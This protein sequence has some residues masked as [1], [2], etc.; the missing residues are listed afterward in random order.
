MSNEIF[1]LWYKQ[2]AMLTSLPEMALMI[3]KEGV[4]GYGLY[5]IFAD[6]LHISGGYREN[7]FDDISLVLD[8]SKKKIKMKLKRVL[9]DYNLFDYYVDDDGVEMIGLQRVREDVETLIKQKL[10]GAKGGRK[11]ARN[12]AEKQIN[13]VKSNEKISEEVR[14]VKSEMTQQ[15]EELMYQAMYYNGN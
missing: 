11:R 14:E 12:Q 8:C 10:N 9:D 6:S 4:E 13:R 2:P 7:N 15:E 3:K 5:M 1:S